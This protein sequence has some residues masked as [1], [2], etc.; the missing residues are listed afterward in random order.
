MGLDE[1]HTGE[2]G[3]TFCFLGLATLVFTILIPS[4]SKI[5]HLEVLQLQLVVGIYIIVAASAGGLWWHVFRHEIF[6]TEATYLGWILLIGG[7][8]LLTPLDR[9]LEHLEPVNPPISAPQPADCCV[10]PA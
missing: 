8:F 5:T 7:V 3:Y 10:S 4:I 9:Y 1:H 2:S 6:A